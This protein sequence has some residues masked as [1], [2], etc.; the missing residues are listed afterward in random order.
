MLKNNMPLINK[1]Y[2]DLYLEKICK[3]KKPNDNENKH[4]ILSNDFCLNF[5]SYN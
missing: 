2:Y 5:K 3:N 1:N 4:K